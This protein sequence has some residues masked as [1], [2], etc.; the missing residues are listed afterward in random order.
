MSTKILVTAIKLS[1]F[2]LV[3][4]MCCFF[5]FDYAYFYSVIKI[6]YFS[7]FSKNVNS[8]IN[9][10]GFSLETKKQ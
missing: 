5:F 10:F 3:G 8:F 9:H 2:L 1:Q 6:K 4:H 7:D